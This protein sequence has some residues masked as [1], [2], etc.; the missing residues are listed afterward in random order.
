MNFSSVESWVKSLQEKITNELARV[1]C[2]SGW[3]RDGWH[4]DGIGEGT[5]CV[6]EN[7][8]TFERVA[9]NMSSV[10]GSSLPASASDRR[11][12][13]RGCSFRATGISVIVHPLN[14]YVPTAHFN[15]RHFMAS[16]NQDQSVWWFG[17]GF[18]LTPYYGFDE[19]CRHWHQT[20][21]AACAPFGADV[22]ADFKRWCDSYFF[23][24]HRNE[25][26]GIGGLFFDDY[27][28]GGDFN[29]AWGLARSIGNH[30]LPAYLPIVKRRMHEPWGE[31]ERD[32][33]LWR[34]GRYV[35]FNL[36]YDRGTLFGLQSSGRIESILASLPPT[37]HWHYD[38]KPDPGSIEAAFL[39]HYLHPRDWVE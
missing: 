26:R 3:S 9:V 14:P 37:V 4:T 36:V 11:P 32:F 20:A 12:D 30:F 38:F 13:L 10:S 21:L 27:D 28:A 18:D 35:E 39:E 15:L 5:T 19:D 22:Y 31:R 34:R 7:G 25:S 8:K 1:G 6:I 33:Q 2:E 17:G 16:Q 24:K 29:S 23:I